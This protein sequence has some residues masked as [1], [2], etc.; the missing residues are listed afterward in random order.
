VVVLV[1]LYV[2]AVRSL[3]FFVLQTQ[4]HSTEVREANELKVGMA[5]LL[6]VIGSVVLVVL[7]YFLDWISYLL[8]I[9]FSLS[10]F[11]CVTYA[12]SPFFSTLARRL[13]L[14]PEYRFVS[15]PL[16]TRAQHT[17]NTRTHAPGSFRFGRRGCQPRRS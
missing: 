17:H 12:L 3:S 2:G 1:T 8:V 11:V 13:H 14:S 15:K 5:V 6:P 4:H 9:V 16:C 10:S 7:F